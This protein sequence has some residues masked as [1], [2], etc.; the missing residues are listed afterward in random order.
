MERVKPGSPTIKRTSSFGTSI[1][2]W[3]PYLQGHLAMLV[4]S[5]LVAG[6]FSLGSIVANEIAPSAINAIRFSMATVL[7]GIVAFAGPG[8]RRCHFRAPWRYLVLGGLLASYFLTMFEGLKTAEPVS[9]AAIFTLIPLF[10]GI[11]GYILLRQVMTMRMAIALALAAVGAYAVLFR[12]DFSQLTKMNLGRGEFVYLIGCAIHGIYTPMV[13]KMNR[14]EGAINFVFGTLLAGSIFLIIFGF[15]DIRATNWASLPIIFWVTLGYLV[16]FA[17]A[18]SFVL[19]QFAA[20][21]L[22]S[23]KVMAYTYLTPVW[24]IVWEII[25]GNG[26]PSHLVFPGIFL[27]VGAL[28]LLIKN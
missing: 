24:V 5:L 4:Y 28:F 26:L 1:F 22:P 27:T 8:I 7:M 3:A 17:T 15:N 25:L 2:L 21:R 14:G 12:G 6:S 16:V 10:A 13:S 9:A 18:A 11:F 20:L 19:I 23:A